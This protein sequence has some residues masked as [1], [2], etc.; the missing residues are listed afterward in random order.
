MSMLW[1]NICM[2]S[3]PFDLDGLIAILQQFLCRLRRTATTGV[4]PRYSM[5]SHK[6]RT[7][8]ASLP[9]VRTR[10][11]IEKIR[12]K[13]NERFQGFCG[14]K[15]KIYKQNN[16]FILKKK[17]HFISKKKIKSRWATQWGWRIWHVRESV[18]LALVA[19]RCRGGG[20]RQKRWTI[21]K[22]YVQLKWQSLILQS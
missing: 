17:T 13:G 11:R 8:S 20:A 10:K 9:P 22:M 5:F 18:L 15:E 14:K 12:N 2:E 19:P 16:V 1:L 7:R 21:R 4:A 6:P 3:R